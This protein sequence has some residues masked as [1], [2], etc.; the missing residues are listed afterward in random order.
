MVPTGIPAAHQTEHWG[1]TGRPTYV[2]L[3]VGFG[4]RQ[5]AL[6]RGDWVLSFGQGSPEQREA[7]DAPEIGQDWTDTRGGPHDDSFVFPV[8]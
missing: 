2:A 4:E 7:G 1:G 3:K 6:E 8:C 5:I